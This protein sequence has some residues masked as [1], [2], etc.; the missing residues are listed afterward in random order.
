[1]II[2]IKD[3][4]DVVD[5]SLALA[6]R[7]F[8]LHK[9]RP[10]KYRLEQISNLHKGLQKMR[11]EISEAVRLDLGRESFATWFCELAIIEHDCEHL[12]RNL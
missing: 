2:T 5:E 3:N 6:R 7:T 4:T 8:N 10:I 1:M 12:L 11:P 9:T